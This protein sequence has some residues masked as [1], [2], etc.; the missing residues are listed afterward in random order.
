L[1]FE[2]FLNETPGAIIGAEPGGRWPFRGLVD[3]V[4]LWTRALS[5][6]EIQSLSGIEPTALK[7][8]RVHERDALGQYLLPPETSAAERACFTNDE[9]GKAIASQITNDP[10]YPQFH[11]ALVGLPCNLQSLYHG[12]RHHYMLV[13]R[14]EALNH[15]EIFRHLVSDDLVSWEIKPAPLGWPHPIWPNGTFLSGP[16]E[17]PC[18]VGGY[19]ITLATAEDTELN[20][21]KVRNDDVR[22]AKEHP[23][24]TSDPRRHPGKLKW[25]EGVTWTQDGAWFMAG[26]GSHWDFVDDK[27]KLH[28]RN[29]VTDFPLYRSTDLREW[30]HVGS[31]FTNP[32][33]KHLPLGVECAQMIPLD[34]E[35][36]LWSFT[37]AYLVGRIR[38]Q[39]FVM[40]QSGSFGS[41]GSFVHWG[42][43]ERDD[44]GRLILQTTK[45]LELP[46]KELARLGWGRTHRLPLAATLAPDSRL[47][48]QPVEE[49]TKLRRA[50]AAL[51]ARSLKPDETL[52]FNLPAS[53]HQEICIEFTATGQ[54]GVHLSDGTGTL[55]IYHDAARQLLCVD[56]RKL[57]LEANHVP[58]D[59]CL[60]TQPLVC[61]PGDKITLRVFQDGALTEIFAN[62][63]NDVQWAWFTA[64]D[65]LRPSVFTRAAPSTLIAADAWQLGPI[66]KD[67]R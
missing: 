59:R 7:P 51:G 67:I 43:W 11:M 38:Q 64:P 66:W 13:H 55:D 61:K 50:H 37:H 44:K 30:R 10:W 22:I 56:A 34:G 3:H 23:D 20:T 16:D 62:D 58:N 12:G 63:V 49:M 1:P 60:F 52:A 53:A 65:Q 6:A 2:F 57:P 26:G 39:R 9:L 14:G 27:G 18:I 25:E 31:F 54:T 4:A 15:N 33:P 41:P 29:D 19:P 21:W 47:I 46:V 40:E 17:R 48:L 45:L 36:W 35:H 24:Y 32:D 28:R 8:Q 42:G 5:E